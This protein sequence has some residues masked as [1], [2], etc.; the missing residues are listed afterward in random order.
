MRIK[1]VEL[2]WIP[3]D[4]EH[5]LEVHGMKSQ[6]ISDRP[7]K[8]FSTLAKRENMFCMILPKAA[9]GYYRAGQRR[10]AT[11]FSD[12]LSPSHFIIERRMKT[13]SF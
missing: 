2:L 9:L 13:S 12:P 11:A 10:K 5:R 7:H 8:A 1:K 3:P 6:D 4:S